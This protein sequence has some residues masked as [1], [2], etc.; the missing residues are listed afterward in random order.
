MRIEPPAI[1]ALGNGQHAIADHGRATAGRTA[2]VARQVKRVAGRAEQRIVADTA[3]PHHRAVGRAEQDGTGPLGALGKTG[4][5]VE[6]VLRQCANA[7]ES[8]RPAWLEIEQ[9]LDCGR[10]TV[11]RAQGFAAHH[12]LLGSASRGAGFVER[13]MDHRIERWIAFFDPRDRGVDHVH[14][15]QRPTAN[16]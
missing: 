9:V 10:D 14:R 12:C 5:L 7:T 2:A 15:R 6:R 13:S 8:H 16:K 3:K 4:S 11:Q 1:G